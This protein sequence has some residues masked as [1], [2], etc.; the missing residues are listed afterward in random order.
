MCKLL[1]YHNSVIV[2]IA[3]VATAAAV[4]DYEFMIIVIIIAQYEA[5]SNWPVCAVV[6]YLVA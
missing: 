1:S 5:Y 2:A 4:I 3:S 6:V